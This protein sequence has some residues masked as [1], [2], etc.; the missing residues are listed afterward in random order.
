MAGPVYYYSST[1]QNPNKLP[2]YYDGSLFIY[3]WI[4][5]WIMAVRMNEEGAYTGMEQFMPSTRFAGII[6]MEVAPDG[7]LY[8]LEYGLGWYSN[9]PQASLS[10]LFYDPDKK[11]SD[12]DNLAKRG[13]NNNSD[14]TQNNHL[15]EGKALISNS[16]CFACHQLDKKSVGPSFLEISKAYENRG[17]EVGRLANRI[18]NGGG[19]V[20]GEHMM[21]AH[22]QF[23]RDQAKK[24]VEYILS[25][26]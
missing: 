23:S 4:R 2:A 6:D 18:I 11:Q 21:S 3:D 1:S 5:N 16:D 25:I 7:T 26:K 17:N 14:A 9:N 8:I 13:I 22:P 24:M 15:V 20:W 12:L 19:G 10:R